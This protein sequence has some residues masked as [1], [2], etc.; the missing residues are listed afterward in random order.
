MLT[1]NHSL[2]NWTVQIYIYA[3]AKSFI[4]GAMG[5]IIYCVLLILSEV[6]SDFYQYNE[7]VK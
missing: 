1:L 4:A 2:I 7:L 6:A 5:C 3:E